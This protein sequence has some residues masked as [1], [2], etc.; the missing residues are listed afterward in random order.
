MSNEM[1]VGIVSSIKVTIYHPDADDPSVLR[2]TG[3]VVETES[4]P[5]IGKRVV[6]RPDGDVA[7]EEC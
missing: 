3:E 1:K 7:Y 4:H 2:A 5:L 6:L